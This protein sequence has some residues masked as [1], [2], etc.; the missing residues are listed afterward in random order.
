[1]LAGPGRSPLKAALETTRILR[2]LLRSVVEYKSLCL[3]SYLDFQRDI[4]PRINRIE[5][6]PPLVRSQQLL[7]LLDAGV[8]RVPLG[9]SPRLEPVAGGVRAR[10]TTL[11]RPCEERVRLAIRGHLD[12]PSLVQTASPLLRGLHER[13]RLQPLRY[14]D[15]AVGSVEIDED[16]HPLDID[17]HAQET[18]SVLG[19]L[20][21]GVRYFTHYLPSPKSRLRAVI[22][23]QAV[24]EALVS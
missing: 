4:R 3:E 2:D 17:G 18:I 21:E 12:L 9:P 13:G 15:V 7:A 16:F 1:S 8:V 10:S 24:A 6:G 19:V 11:Q 5:A 22:D 14:G 23:A 20:T